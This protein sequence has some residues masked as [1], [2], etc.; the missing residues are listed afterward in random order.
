MFARLRDWT[1]SLAQRRAA[2]YWLAFLCFAESSV[3]PIPS[4]LL[5]VPM[6]LIRM[7]KVWRYA[8]ISSIFSVLGGI[9]GWLIGFYAYDMLARPILDFY[10]V[11]EEFEGWRIYVAGNVWLILL[12]LVTSGLAHLPP[13]KIVTILSGAIGFNFWV[14]LLS[15]I[16]ARTAR[17]YLLAW[18]VKRYGV[19]ILGFLG[20][21]LKQIVTG[22]VVA[23]IAA[24][25]GY[26]VFYT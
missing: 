18:L 8:L 16:V 24:A 20:R 3:F 22:V 19:A 17:F 2:E 5:F 25:V 11:Y 9:F 12:L 15:A 4:D 21:R 14:F 1:V 10:G 13:M 23:V 6:A 26:M 7:D